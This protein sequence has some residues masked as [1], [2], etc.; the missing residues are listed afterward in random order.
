M[1]GVD[2]YGCQLLRSDGQVTPVFTAIAGVTN[3]GG[4]E[5]EREAYESTHH[6]SPDGWREYV[7]GLKDGGEISIEV[8]YD[9]R[10]HDA[11]VDDFEDTEARDYRLV[12][13]AITGAQWDISA[14]LTGFSPEGPHD[15]LLAAELTLKVTG[16]PVLS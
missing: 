3:L 9:P 12:W 5:I 10:V 6:G 7:G 14:I 16:K 1:A 8:R 13:P 4:P 2:G 15:D 11:L